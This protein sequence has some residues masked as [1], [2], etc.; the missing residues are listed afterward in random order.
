MSNGRVSGLA[1]EH[2]ATS[3]NKT[4]AVDTV[5]QSLGALAW[6]VRDP[7]TNASSPLDL[8]SYVKKFVVFHGGRRAY[9]T[10]CLLTVGYFG[11]YTG[12]KIHF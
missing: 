8:G 2:L 12:R 7:Y 5:P 4:F 6:L 10:N 11:L 9:V 1:E 3:M